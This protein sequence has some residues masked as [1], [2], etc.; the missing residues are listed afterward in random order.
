MKNLEKDAQ[1]R[2]KKKCEDG[3]L[4]GSDSNSQS[5]LS[6]ENKCENVDCILREKNFVKKD[7]IRDKI[8]KCLGKDDCC[9]VSD[10]SKHCEEFNCEA[11]T[12]ENR[13]KRSN[14]DIL[15]KA[16]QKRLQSKCQ[17]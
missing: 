15:S 12:D 2:L 6:S 10:N 9:Y 5:G 4:D 16:V 13:N 3:S 8:K 11:V 17:G 1:T 14:I 7:S